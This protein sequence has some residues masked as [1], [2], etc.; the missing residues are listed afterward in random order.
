MYVRVRFACASRALR[1]RGTISITFPCLSGD[2]CHAR[3]GRDCACRRPSSACLHP[4]PH[5][6]PP[7]PG[8][9]VCATDGEPIFGRPFKVSMITGLASGSVSQAPRTPRA[10]TRAF[11]RGV[12]ADGLRD[13][14]STRSR[15]RSNSSVT[16]AATNPCS[17]ARI[18][19]SRSNAR[20]RQ[21]CWRSAGSTSTAVGLG[22]CCPLQHGPMPPESSRRAPGA[23]V[24]DES[25]RHGYFM[26][27]MVA[28]RWMLRRRREQNG[29]VVLMGRTCASR[30]TVAST[31]PSLGRA[32][33]IRVG[34]AAMRHIRE[35][36]TS[37]GRGTVLG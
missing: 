6:A 32:D 4:S 18:A 34:A 24:R 25:P 29:L 27:L 15:T 11:G 19:R 21:P 3:A 1:V 13:L 36:E 8:G 37:G 10:I 16:A 33:G 2:A 23:N 7:R 17:S 30:Q 5:C 20:M 14:K 9:V 35:V 31:R 22:W 28:G 12:R 26:N